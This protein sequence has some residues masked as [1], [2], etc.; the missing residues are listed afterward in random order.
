MVLTNIF[1]FL[2]RVDWPLLLPAFLLTLL[3]IVE[4]YSCSLTSHN[5][6]SFY[7]QLIAFLVALALVGALQFFD[8]RAL[9]ANSYLVFGFY[10]LT[11]LALLGVLFFGVNVRGNQGW[12]KLGPV[13][14]EPVPFM[15][16][17]LMIILAKFFSSRHTE[18]NRLRIVFFSGIYAV[19]PMGL[20][21]LQP[22]LGS[23]LGLLAIWLGIVFFSGMKLRHL[24]LLVVLFCLLFGL[25]WQFWLKDYQKQRIL[26]FLNPESDRQG[27]S[28]NVNQS[29]IAIGSG[30]LWGKG[31]GKGSQVQYGF[32]PEPKTDFIFSALAEETGFLGVAFIFTGFLVIFWRILLVTFWAQDNFTRLFATGFCCFLLSQVF[33][34][35]GM[36]LG[37]FPVVG[38]PLPFVSYGGSYLL[39]SYFGLGLLS[40]LQ[41]RQAAA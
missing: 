30:G 5:F 15:A 25:G 39:A 18:L 17:A 1:Y 22:D 7:K 33:I 4:I 32:L 41:R 14:F 24:L 2:K 29:K 35:V 3:G 40:A 12:Y 21:L 16:V 10:L 28:W 23:A 38:I 26:S 34:N 13:F 9:K 31:I 11:V 37:L 8:W 27:V 36:C 6:T 19:I 20:V